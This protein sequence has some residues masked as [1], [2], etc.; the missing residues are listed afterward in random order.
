MSQTIQFTDVTL[1][2]GN[3]SIAATRMTRAQSL[4]VLKMIADAGF[5]TLELWGGA[6]LDSC[7]RYLNEDPWERL[8]IYRQTLGGPS[9]I[10]ALLR[11]QNLFA[12]QPYPDDLVISFVKQAC[13]SGVGV[14]RMFDALN[15]ERNLLLA[16]MATKTYGAKAEAA[17]SY[18]VSP[19]H[20]T[21]YFVGYAR[22]L[23]DMGADQLAI[24]DMAGLLQPAD[25]VEL[26]RGIKAATRLPLALHSHTTTGVG[27]LNAV[28]G[29]VH[30]VDS[31]DCAITPFAGGSSHPPV[32]LLVAFA[33]ELGLQHGLDKALLER[34]QTELFAISAELKESI[35]DYGKYYR[36]VRFED[37]DR[38]AVQQI[39]K[40]V[41]SGSR[42]EIDSALALSRTMLADLGYPAYDDRIFDSQIPGG[43]ISNLKNQLKQMG[44][45][46]L[47]DRL[48]EEIPL[49]RRDVGYV[50][51][52]T[53]TSQIIGS[54]A[55]FNLMTGERYAMASDEFR[56]LLRGEFGRTPVQ[57][58]AGV[59]MK[60]L[61]GDQPP[62]K[63]R[64]ASYLKPVLEDPHD[65]PFVRSH[66]D[67]L[68]HLLF[69]QAA[70]EFLKKRDAVPA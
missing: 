70:D 62:L 16:L 68:L 23:Q 33:E 63:Y 19:V 61:G 15:D 51:L 31:I 53:P 42:A 26:I 2:D 9:R 43:M 56:M 32:E 36:P 4:R 59:V 67:L 10:Q 11:G 20:T 25:A 6:I 24:K 40:R 46:D 45:D 29:M 28:V 66:K 27:L 5:P 3:Q 34:I 44:Q 8:E 57:P 52:V 12:Y 17:I 49:V 38:H 13:E 65:L 39:L 69:G 60:V 41:Q 48:M 35:P 54:Q 47:L 58:D 7:I 64:P 50:P 21:D 30:G 18:T 14:M 37:V 22:K 55:A 1:R